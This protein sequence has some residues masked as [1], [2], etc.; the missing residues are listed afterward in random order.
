MNPHETLI[1]E[2]LN[3]WDEHLFFETA[4]AF[5]RNPTRPNGQAPKVVV[6][7]Y[8]EQHRQINAAIAWV[9]THSEETP[10]KTSL[11]ISIRS[12][13]DETHPEML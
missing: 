13:A 9:K 8:R 7:A 4:Q 11:P 3:R 10:L 12:I 6:N 2:A 5:Q 1:V